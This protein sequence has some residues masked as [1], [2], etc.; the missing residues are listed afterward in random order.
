MDMDNNRICTTAL[1]WQHEGKQKVEQPKTTWRRR[2]ETE[3]DKL[4]MNTWSR[5]K[6]V[7]KDRDKLGMNS[8]SRAKTVAKDRDKWKQFVRA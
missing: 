6:T 2:V 5:A 4:G 1:M 3:R 7:A 8:W